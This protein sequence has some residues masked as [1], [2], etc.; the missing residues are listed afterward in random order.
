MART[1]YIAANWKMNTNKE[2]AVRLAKELDYQLKEKT[3][4]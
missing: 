4:K 1:H 3:N 2:E